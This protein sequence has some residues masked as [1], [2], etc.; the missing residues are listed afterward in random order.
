MMSHCKWIYIFNHN[1]ELIGIVKGN[2]FAAKLTGMFS[3]RDINKLANEKRMIG[4]E[5]G[6]YLRYD[7]KIE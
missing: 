2:H 5:M 4:N 3:I 7:D 1:K 6:F